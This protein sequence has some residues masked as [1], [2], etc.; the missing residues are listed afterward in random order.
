MF[1]SDIKILTIHTLVRVCTKKKFKK[2]KNQE[3]REMNEKNVYTYVQIFFNTPF[4][5]RPHWRELKSN[6]I[7]TSNL[8]T[9]FSSFHPT[10]HPFLSLSFPRRSLYG[11]QMIFFFF[12]FYFSPVDI[13]TYSSFLLFRTTNLR[14]F[15]GKG[16]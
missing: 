2:K 1:H 13:Y 7:V 5:V 3:S 11:F 6:Y 14:F 9:V 15:G 4:I 8:P 16:I 10:L 12:F